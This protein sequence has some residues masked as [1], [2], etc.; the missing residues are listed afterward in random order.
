MRIP[1]GKEAGAWMGVEPHQKPSL[2][3]V[4]DVLTTFHRKCA[5]QRK[6]LSTHPASPQ[7][8]VFINPTALH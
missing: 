5:G 7:G 1:T 4:P 6:A 8:A 3:S 2:T